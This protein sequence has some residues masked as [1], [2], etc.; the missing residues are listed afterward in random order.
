[1]NFFEVLFS[2]TSLNSSVLSC[3]DL[4]ISCNITFSTRWK[5]FFSRDLFAD[6]MSVHNWIW[7]DKF[8]SYVIKLVD[9]SVAMTLSFV[10][11]NTIEDKKRTKT[12]KQTNEQT[13]ENCNFPLHC[14]LKPK[15]SQLQSLNLF[16]I[17]Y[18]R[19]SSW[20]NWPSISEIHTLMRRSD[21]CEQHNT[22]HI[23]IV[24]FFTLKKYITIQKGEMAS[25]F[26]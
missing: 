18:Q 4:L 15:W 17:L 10:T 25:V 23:N 16:Y 12:N 26:P 7:L 22:L 2:T 21:R 19:H 14:L 24:F 13:H 5:F 6:L 1:M 11:Q 3:E 20:K 9:A 8:T